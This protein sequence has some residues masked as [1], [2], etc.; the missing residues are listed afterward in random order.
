MG[1]NDYENNQPAGFITPLIAYRVNG[2][3]SAPLAASGASR[4][5]NVVTFTTQAFHPFRQG[6]KVTIAGV[7]NSSF[8]GSF[9]V[10]SR[11]SDTSFTVAQIGPNES[12]G[13]GTATTQNI[14]GSATGG[15]FYDSTAFP[16]AYRGNYF[17]G[18]VNTGNVVRATLDSGDVP[19]SVDFFA[20]AVN[21][22]VDS[23]IG[24]DGALYIAQ[25]GFSS[26]RR[27][28]TTSTAQNLIVQPTALGVPEGGGAIFTVRLAQ[29]PGANVSVTVSKT[30]GD[31]DLALASA[32]TLTFTP[33]NWNQIQAVTITAA[34]DADL[35]SGTAT[36]SVSATGLGPY[37]VLATEI[38]NDE[39]RLVLSQNNLSLVENG[40][41]TFQVSLASAPAADVTVSVARASGDTDLNVTGGALLT[42]TPLNFGTA[43][44]VTIAAADDGDNVG[45]SAVFSV[46]LAGEPVRQVNVTATDND[47]AAP[48]IT[49]AFK[50]TAI[51]GALYTYDVN[52]TGNP[53][54]TYVFATTPPTGMTINNTTGLI[55]WTP[56]ATGTFPISVRAQNG[57]APNATQSYNIVVSNDGP[58]TAVIT[59][60]AAGSVLSGT[61]AEFFG[62]GVDDVGT[63][64]AEFFVDGVLA[65]TDTS[66][67][68]HYHINGTHALFDTTQYTNGPHTLRMRVTDTA[69]QTGLLDV[70][71]SIGN[72]IAGW[73][74]EKFTAAEQANPAISGDLADPEGDGLT[75]LAEYA[76]NLPP[77]ASSTTGLPTCAI[78]N[79]GGTNYLTL[80]FTR[81]KWATDLT[82]IV[83]ADGD[84]APPWQQID[85]LLPQNQVSVLD[86]TPSFGL[87]TITVKDVVPA[88]AAP[89]YMR[90]R[91][92]K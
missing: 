88:G 46:T 45:D 18:D 8:N 67:G 53:T 2:T 73:R 39:P 35:D 83:E 89:R 12:S 34:E 1:W 75:N 84:L 33:A 59:Q 4:L 43:Q 27:I 65:Y 28:A 3:T 20:T 86:D 68:Q 60:P 54:P 62:D 56:S 72:Q 51:V 40:S 66:A 5:S 90:L 92:S 91:I 77:K 81:V 52:A 64:K 71:V 24:P 6:A 9:Y 22:A 41:G 16:A 50:S 79:V 19:T 85:P 30:G 11:V 61:N 58:P 74:K 36:F 7:A 70:Q 47:N 38:E 31:A 55:N 49:S 57:V 32:G 23:A 48:V 26:V 63:V 69:G 29:A 82:Y 10:T 80:T 14:G 42:F 87:Q 21:Q 15:C 17:F 76:L 37:S 44:T 25:A 78:M 13:G